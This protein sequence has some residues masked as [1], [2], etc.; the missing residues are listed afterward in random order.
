MR[1][2]AFSLCGEND[3]KVIGDLTES[4]TGRATPVL[5]VETEHGSSILR[6]GIEPEAQHA[7]EQFSTSGVTPELF[8]SGVYN[9]FRWALAEWIDGDSLLDEAITSGTPFEH[10][11]QTTR[12]VLTT[13]HKLHSGAL[14][15]AKY[16][17]EIIR[18]AQ[19]REAFIVSSMKVPE[20]PH[21]GQI[22]R[23]LWL[24]AQ[25]VHGDLLMTNVL[26]QRDYSLRLIDAAGGYGPPEFDA[27]WWLGSICAMTRHNGFDNYT[28]I[29]DFAVSYLEQTLTN[30]TWL[31]RRR[32]YGWTAWALCEFALQEQRHGE[33]REMYRGLVAIA[34]KLEIN[35]LHTYRAS[36]SIGRNSPCTC[37][38]GKKFKKC[39]GSPA[40]RS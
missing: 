31:D 39:C 22:A 12:Q 33:I 8:S 2:L 30:F 21:L 11:C 28:D 27:G 5:R 10:L 1:A 32:L 25:L 40:A 36:M 13:V 19:E 9:D 35:G 20:T 15:H 37:G 3:W 26:R 16:H 34:G 4:T 29:F 17:Q 24:P 6:L 18:V 38:S 23:D 7:Y 14:P